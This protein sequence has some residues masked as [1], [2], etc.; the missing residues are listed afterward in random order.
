MEN[1]DD[2]L[3]QSFSENNLKEILK[4]KNAG[5]KNNKHQEKG[6]R[7]NNTKP[8]LELDLHGYCGVDAKKEIE[9]FIR[10]AFSRG[11][12]AVRIITGR[13]VH[14]DAGK[15]ILPT[16]AKEK[17]MELKEKN[18]ITHYK[19]DNYHNTKGGSVI[20]YLQ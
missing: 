2:I 20:V 7:T 19:W 5:I 10:S 8:Q 1:F 4:E 12:K 17:L 18:I 9:N 6:Q 13:G 3:E 15:L 14:S 11:L 16:V